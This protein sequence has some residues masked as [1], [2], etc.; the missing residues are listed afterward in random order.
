MMIWLTD[1]MVCYFKRLI[2]EAI[3]NEHPAMFFPV[4]VFSFSCRID[5]AQHSAADSCTTTACRQTDRTAAVL[6]YQT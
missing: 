5:Y 6:L 3:L 4:Y 1:D 2:I